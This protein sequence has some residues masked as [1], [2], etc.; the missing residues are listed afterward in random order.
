MVLEQ[1]T[2]GSSPE[3]VRRRWWSGTKGP[4]A[5]VRPWVAAAR[6]EM[7]RGGPATRVAAAADG[8]GPVRRRGSDLQ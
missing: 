2:R 4:R 8:D 3:E 6:P 1:G 5:R 7:A